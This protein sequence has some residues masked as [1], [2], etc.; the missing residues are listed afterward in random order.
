MINL[1]LVSALIASFSPTTLGVISMS[2][3]KPEPVNIQHIITLKAEEYGLDSQIVG[4]I[5]SCESGGNQRAINTNKN[6]SVDKGLLQINSVHDIGDLDLF[7]P[8]DNLDF[9]LKLMQKQG[10]RPWDSSRKCWAFS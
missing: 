1:I 4:K 8:V 5:I 6:G 10:T 9:G 2:P 3:P 7:D